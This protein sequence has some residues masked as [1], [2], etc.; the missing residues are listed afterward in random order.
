MSVAMRLDQG[1]LFPVETLVRKRT[2]GR[3]ESMKRLSKRELA[4]DGAVASAALRE[5]EP[6]HRRRPETRAE[7]LPGGRN[8]ARP[9]PYASCVH[10]LA[11]DVSERSGAIKSN[12]PHL[13]V[14]EMPETCALDVADRGGATLEEV[15]AAMNLT[16]ERV[17]QLET[18]AL[19]AARGTRDARLAA[20]IADVTVLPGEP[21]ALREPRE[22]AGAEG[23]VEFDAEAARVRET[24]DRHADPLDA[25]PLSEV[26]ALWSA[27]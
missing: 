24:F 6:E 19:N 8:E 25:L 13:E 20:G 23:L 12:F 15:A 17:R 27:R 26:A 7:C 4:R 14:W 10:H 11:L 18:R 21:Q 16:R 1:V 22:A 5:V 2:F 9:C 3:T